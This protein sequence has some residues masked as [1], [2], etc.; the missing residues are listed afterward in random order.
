MQ[1]RNILA[2]CDH[3]DIRVR[4]VQAAR[5]FY[6]ALCAA[7]GLTVVDAGEGSIT[8][9]THDS[10]DAFVAIDSDPTFVPSHTRIAF[11]AASRDMV[12]RVA[13]AVRAA[14]AT[15]FEPPHACLEYSEGYYASFFSDADGNR[16][17]VC[18]RPR[19]SGFILERTT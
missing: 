3:L 5:G 19:G 1:D 12:D 10:S 17:E 6:E 14:G 8:F 15:E 2:L 11:R 18:H 16:Y 4:D 13:E 7:L 9:E